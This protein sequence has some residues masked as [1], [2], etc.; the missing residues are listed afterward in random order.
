[1]AITFDL[2]K[3]KKEEEQ[4]PVVGTQYAKNLNAL[5]SA[6]TKRY[7][8][9]LS[10]G[11]GLPNTLG[12]QKPSFRSSKDMFNLSND[13]LN[14]SRTYQQQQKEEQQ[15]KPLGFQI[16]QQKPT[17]PSYISG[18]ENLAER[19]KALLDK[20]RQ[21]AGDYYNKSYNE[22]NRLL[23]QSIPML[24][25]QLRGATAN[26]QKGIEGAEQSAEYQKQN[27]RDEWGESQRLAAQ[28]RNESE[29]R[30]RN[31]FAALNTTDSYGAGSY[32]QAQENVESDF[33]R[34]TQQGLRQREQDIFAIDQALQNYQLEA[35]SQID[36][37]EA[38]LANTVNEIQSSI[39]LNEIEKQ[40]MLDDAFNKY[41]QG[42]LA[43]EEG[44]KNVYAQYYQALEQSQASS[45][46][47]E[48][49]AT[50][51][52]QNEND[53]RFY[54]EN[55]DKVDNLT[56]GGQSSAAQQAFSLAD[57]LLRMD[58]NK[59]SGFGNKLATLIPG[60]SSQLTKNK[61]DQLKA[62]LSLDNI[63]ML[64]GTGQISDKEQE[65]LENASTSLGRNLSDVAFK[66]VLTDLRNELG[67]LQTANYERPPLETF[68]NKT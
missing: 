23:Q 64:K 36:T 10:S 59:I 63:Q 14:K 9:S 35:Q 1:M 22:R 57:E 19:Q 53:Y 52:P 13:L 62:L 2:F 7:T 18:Y 11:N 29:A 30:N 56:G 24:Q 45:L 48:F 34:F 27:R 37:L 15:E 3:K 6:T 49:M 39:N 58:T 21:Q 31:R 42:V 60:T 50:G 26:I 41:Q 40:S 33:N 28:T 54:I 55:Q 61:Y 8:D 5:N 38:S 20:Q 67:G 46:S 32:G 44:M 43:V 47:P 17:I 12:L 68:E 4:Q 65:I 16:Q 66:K 51:I 25:Q